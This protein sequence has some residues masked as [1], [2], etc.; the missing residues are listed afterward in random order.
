[1][2]FK[3]HDFLKVNY[4]AKLKDG[5][6]FD[7]TVES[8][9]K[10]HQLGEG[11][12]VPTIICLGEGFI[13]P[14]IEKNLIGKDKGKFTFEL[15]AIDAFGK[16]DA[17][18]MRLFPTSKF[19]EQNVMPEPGVVVNMDGRMGVIK[20]VTGG[21][22][23]VDFNHPLSG[24]DVIYEVDVLDIVT[25]MA[26]KVKAVVSNILEASAHVELKENK[27]TIGIHH[28][29]PPQILDHFKKKIIELTGVGDI[30]FDVHKQ[31]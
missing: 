4:T 20:T 5:S 24:K 28:E 29:I 25:D 22:T 8:V 12:F 26:E 19:I 9:G 31:H 18:M 21:R 3:E 14:S 30:A 1:M 2:A 27:A 16:K 7:T 11:P 6:V 10:E 17:K 15:T 13:L 23:T